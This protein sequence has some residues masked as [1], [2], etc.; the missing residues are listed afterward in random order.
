[1]SCFEPLHGF[2]VGHTENK[3][4]KLQVMSNKV[5]ALDEHNQPIYHETADPNYRYPAYEL[6]CGHCEG[7]RAAQSREWSNR[8]LMESLYHDSSLFVT[9]TYD[10]EHIPVVERLDEET[11]EYFINS[12]LRKSDIQKFIKRLRQQ[13]PND[14]IRYYVA[15][16]YG[17]TTHRAHWHAIIYGLHLVDMQPF[18]AS[19]TG[20][21]YYISKSLSDIWRNGFVSVEPANDYT[22]R[23]VANYVTKK[24]GIRPNEEYERLGITPPCSMQ[25]LKPGIGLQYLKDHEEDILEYDRIILGTENGSYNFKPP[26]YFR[27]KIDEKDSFIAE[28]Y[29][30]ARKQT[31]IDLKDSEFS[32]TDLDDR[33]YRDIKRES[34]R[35]RV[36]KRDG[37]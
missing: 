3:K 4:V 6:P 1:M 29:H 11:G 14:K 33:E 21:Q 7:C 20:N 13:F 26:R 34:F 18:G 5:F 31:A 32:R 27:K 30:A 8:L 10:D 2:V 35:K 17:E 9:L 22:F 15:G 23:Y 12:T 25:S 19:E 24:I 37:V 28:R 16:E 36:K